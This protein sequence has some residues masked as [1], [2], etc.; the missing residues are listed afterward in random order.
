MLPECP[1]LVTALNVIRKGRDRSPSV[2]TI[3]AVD[4]ESRFWGPHLLRGFGAPATATRAQAHPE[5][6]SGETN[7][8]S[9]KRGKNDYDGYLY[10]RDPDEDLSLDDAPKL[11]I[12]A[13]APE[14]VERDTM[15]R[16]D[17]AHDAWV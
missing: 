13:D 8:M 14:D 6:R 1:L 4:R 5:V 3:A 16:L 2:S 9:G 11:K 12:A 17:H 10:E 15:R 7:A